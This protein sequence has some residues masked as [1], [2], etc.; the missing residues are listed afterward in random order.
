MNTTAVA[1]EK[2]FSPKGGVLGFFLM[3]LGMFMAILD[4]QIVAS[5]LPEIQ[6]GLSTSV[7]RVAWVQTSYLIAEVVMI[8]LSGWL[9]R[10]FSSRW[11]FTISVVGFTLSSALCAFAWDINSMIVFRALQGFIG[12]AMIPTVF[13]ANFKLFPPERQVVGTVVIGLTATIAPAL[14]PT[15]GGWITANMSWHWLFLINLVPGTFVAIAVP[16]VVDIDRGDLSLLKRIDFPGILLVATFLG[17]LE[18]VLDEGP[19][20]SWFQNNTILAYTI[21]SVLS[22]VFL[23]YRELTIEHPVLEWHA[24]GNRNFTVGAVLGFVMGIT[25]YGQTFIIPQL[26]SQV[27]GYNSLQIGHVMFVTGAAMFCTA[28]FA[29]RL[30]NRFDP[31][32]VLVIGFSMVAVGVLLNSFMTVQVGFN[33]LIAPQI[34]RGSGMMLIMVPI[35]AVALG[36]LPQ[37]LVSGGSGMFNLFRNLGGAVGLAVINTQWRS[38]FNEHYWRL[39][40]SLPVGDKQVHAYIQQMQAHLQSHSAQVINPDLAAKALLA[41]QVSLQAN[42][43]SWNDV[44]Q[45]MFLAFVVSAPLIFMLRKPEHVTAGGH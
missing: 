29:G 22:A 19:R 17:P 26:L 27:R 41:R 13:A 8:P 35:T 11:L 3:V 15:I 42:V 10:V 1:A 33:Q 31:R 30:V 40:E 28:P 23:L 37:H 32:R 38:N 9:A 12:G 5:S 43:M 25:L 24:F 4:I 2:A 21:V 20:N 7:D 39:A 6:A 16:L 44:F 18:F 34:F 36:T 14:G 45:L